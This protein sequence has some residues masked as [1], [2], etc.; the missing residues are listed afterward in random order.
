MLDL[1]QQTHDQIKCVIANILVSLRNLGL[2][3]GLSCL[4]KMLCLTEILSWLC[5]SLEQCWH[6][7]LF[8]A[9]LSHSK[10]EMAG[11]CG[12]TFSIDSRNIAPAVSLHDVD[13]RSGLLSIWRHHPHKVLIKA[14]KQWKSDQWASPGQN[15]DFVCRFLVSPYHWGPYWWQSRQSVVY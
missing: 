10:G 7:H 4:I 15:P 6:V 11:V 3:A 12:R 1:F 13:H 9:L 2:T 14:L 8:A 5:K